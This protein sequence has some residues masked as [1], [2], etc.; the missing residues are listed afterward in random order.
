MVL[1]DD[2]ND[3]SQSLADIKQSLTEKGATPP[4]SIT[5]YSHAIDVLSTDGITPEGTYNIERNGTYNI[6]NYENVD[7]DVTLETSLDNLEVTPTTSSQT[8]TPTSG[9][10]GFDEVTVSAVTNDIDSNITAGNIKSGV[11]ILG[12][13][14][15]YEGSIVIDDEMSLSSEN[16]VQNKVI[17]AA[18]NEKADTSS[19]ATVATSGDYDDL[20]NKPTIPDAQVQ[21]NWNESDNT[22]KAYIQN[23]PN[24][25]T[26]A[27]S[28]SYTDL[29]NTPTIPTVNNGTLTITQGGT[30][31]GTFN[32]NSSSDVTIDLDAGGGG[33]SVTVD[34]HLSTSSTNP[35]ENRVVTNAINGK[36]D[37]LTAGDNIVIHSNYFTNPTYDS[38]LASGNVK[39]VTY[40]N[41]IYVAIKNNGD[42]VT[43]SDYS[44]WTVYGTNTLGSNNWTSICYANNTF[45]AIGYSGYVS[46]SQDG[47]TWDTPVQSLG[48]NKWYSITHDGT[49]FV[50]LGETGYLSTST[51]GVT[52]STPAQNSS[53]GSHSW[54]GITYGDGKYVTVSH[55]ANYA[56]VGISSDLSTWTIYQE[57]NLKSSYSRIGIAYG[58]GLFMVLDGHGGV[59]T[60]KDGQHWSKLYN[61][62]K[63][64]NGSTWACLNYANDK[65]L[66][67]ATTYYKSYSDGEALNNIILMPSASSV[68]F[69]SELPVTSKG[70]Y[71]YV[72]GSYQAKLSSGSGISNTD[73]G[74]NI[75]SVECDN[76]VTPLSNNPV[77]GSAVYTALQDKQDTLNFVNNLYTVSETSYSGDYDLNNVQEFQIIDPMDPQWGQFSSCQWHNIKYLN[78]MY[79]ACGEFGILATSSDLQT[80]TIQQITD[81]GQPIGTIN[82]V[83]YHSGTYVVVSNSMGIVATSSN[84]STWTVQS[85]S[86]THGQSFNGTWYDVVYGNN[87][88]VLVGDTG[89]IATTTD[90]SNWSYYKMQQIMDDLKSIVYA[91]ST[92]VIAANYNTIT[93]S[94]GSNWTE[95]TNV[96]NNGVFSDYICYNSDDNKFLV[97]CNQY[98]C[99]SSD[100]AIWNDITYVLGLPYSQMIMC[101]N[102]GT[103]FGINEY[104]NT[105]MKASANNL[106]DWDVQQAMLHSTY[107]VNPGP[108]KF[109]IG[110]EWGFA[111]TLQETTT[112]TNYLNATK[113]LFDINTTSDTIEL[114]DDKYLYLF[115]PE[116]NTTLVF[117]DTDISASATKA[118][119]FEL[120]ID[121]STSYTITFPSS[122]VWNGGTSPTMS[123]TGKYIVDFIT[124]D[125]GTT[126]L[127]KTVFTP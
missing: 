125:G 115:T 21:S 30:T 29:S 31:K 54:K 23:K 117:D 119:T 116:Q 71:N 122:V 12:V 49:S 83:E 73:L 1:S 14:G 97:V 82:S 24:L 52:W 88:Y 51:D 100:G 43:S 102:N 60:S 40:G 86:P 64:V 55:T 79:I 80:W 92:F 9:Y 109:L 70:V 77:S 68:S 39:C 36:Q 47:T 111:G 69:G 50:A 38:A 53:L 28:G 42:V 15:D 112:Q 114:S 85:L 94:D 63:L 44:T 46:T 99:E 98:I 105:I 20:L 113:T 126:W 65:F 8:I 66:V 84:L 22:S 95:N 4:D 118:Y 33:G 18:L 123:S 67:M 72:N 91:N 56:Q 48:N 11:N 5:D 35:V 7:V 16:A 26:V 59:S 62:D 106:Y 76:T 74:N 124:L 87:M 81:Q 45:V 78:N 104:G 6:N 13:T 103:Y 32:A 3:I 120:V 57:D 107:R 110:M 27:T 93:S 10:V 34:D 37:I 25:S 19:L 101:Y 2:L 75:V 89:N 127:G 108:H 121:M 41:S 17:T 58:N 61:D 90:L 96:Y